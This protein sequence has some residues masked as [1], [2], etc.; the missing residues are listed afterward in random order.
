[1]NIEVS[2]AIAIINAVLAIAVFYF[3]R[4]KETQEGSAQSTEVLLELRTVRRDLGELK[5]DV[6][7]MRQ[8]WRD[9]HDTLIGIAREQKAMWKIIDNMQKGEKQDEKN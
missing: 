5:S 9:D 7:S 8:E 1:M 2:Y 6:Q 3:A 4:K